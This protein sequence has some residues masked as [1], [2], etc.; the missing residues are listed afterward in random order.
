MIALPDKVAKGPNDFVLISSVIHA[1]V[2]ALFPGMEITG[3]HQFRVTRNS[4]L[5][6][7]EE[8]NHR[9]D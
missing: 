7:D 8:S 3:S 1:H 9:S 2:G 4:D 5:F 6:V